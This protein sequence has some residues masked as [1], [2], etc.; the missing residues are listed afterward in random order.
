MIVKPDFLDHWKTKRLVALTND[1]GAPLMLIRLWGFC[2]QR[3]QAQFDNLSD[4]A[5]ATICGWSK[6]PDRLKE[7]LTEC[8]FIRAGDEGEK[9]LVVH[10]WEKMNSSLIARWKG[11][12][13]TKAKWQAKPPLSHKLRHSSAKAQIASRVEKNKKKGAGAQDSALTRQG[14]V[15][16]D[17]EGSALQNGEP[18]PSESQRSE[19]HQHFA[20]QLKSLTAK[21]RAAK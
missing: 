14:E 1:S 21:M 12:M 4:H 16:P 15:T 7:I 19:T 6:N 20:E 13:Q 10:N 17:T 8:C 2:E 18:I 5:L 3:R 9:K 11:G